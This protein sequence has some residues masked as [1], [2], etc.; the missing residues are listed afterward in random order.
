[1]WRKSYESLKIVD[2]KNHS[3]FYINNNKSNYDD[4][5]KI[6]DDNIVFLSGQRKYKNCLVRK[7]ILTILINPFLKKS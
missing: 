6:F 4:I 7:I 1:M 2:S 3:T 5:F